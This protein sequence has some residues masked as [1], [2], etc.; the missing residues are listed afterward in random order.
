MCT[1]GAIREVAASDGARLP[2][3]VAYPLPTVPSIAEEAWEPV[4]SNHLDSYPSFPCPRP[5]LPWWTPRVVLHRAL[6]V[7]SYRGTLSR[8]GPKS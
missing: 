3:S 7:D 8:T 6:S 4:D 1:L 2:E 5:S